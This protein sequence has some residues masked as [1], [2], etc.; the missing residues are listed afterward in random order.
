MVFVLKA[1]LF[2]DNNIQNQMFSPAIIKV[3]PII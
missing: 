3:I 2:G 1:D